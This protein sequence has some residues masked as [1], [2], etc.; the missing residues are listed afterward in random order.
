MFPALFCL[1]ASKYRDKRSINGNV[2]G[3]LPGFYQ[4]GKLLKIIYN[5]YHL[6]FLDIDDAT[7][8]I[9]SRF[10]IFSATPRYN[11]TQSS[12][13]CLEKANTTENNPHLYIENISQL[14]DP[15]INAFKD[16]LNDFRKSAKNTLA[17]DSCKII[18]YDKDKADNGYTLKFFGFTFLSFVLLV[19]LVIVISALACVFTFTTCCFCFHGKNA[20]FPGITATVFFWIAFSLFLIAAFIRISSVSGV[21]E[22]VSPITDLENK[23]NTSLTSLSKFLSRK[24]TKLKVALTNIPK[25]RRLIDLFL[26]VIT[27]VQDHIGD[28]VTNVNKTLAYTKDRNGTTLFDRFDQIEKDID[29]F[30]AK[31]EEIKQRNPSQ[32]ADIKNITKPDFENFTNAINDTLEQ[33]KNLSLHS[34]IDPIIDNLQSYEFIDNITKIINETIDL[35]FG[36]DPVKEYITIENFSDVIQFDKVKES[37]I[38]LR[39]CLIILFVIPLFWVLV[40]L[41]CT[42]RAFYSHGCCSICTASCA[43][44]RLCCCTI[45]FGLFC[46]IFTALGVVFNVGG[47]RIYETVNVISPKLHLLFVNP[48]YIL[49]FNITIHLYDTLVLE[50]PQIQLKIPEIVLLGDIY[51][52]TYKT[53]GEFIHAKE[54]IDDST[55]KE[56]DMTFQNFF[57]ETIPEFIQ[58]KILDQKIDEEVKKQ[59][60]ENIT[61]IDGYPKNITEDI[62]EGRDQIDKAKNESKINESDAKE[63]KEILQHL[64]KIITTELPESYHTT[65]QTIDH[66]VIQPFGTKAGV[67]GVWD[68][69][70]KGPYDTLADWIYNRGIKKGVLKI[71]NVI[72][73]FE[74]IH[75]LNCY[76]IIT[77]P[78]KKVI[79][80]FAKRSIFYFFA[81]IA[82]LVFGISLYVRRRGMEWPEQ[83]AKGDYIC[84]KKKR[85]YKSDSGYG[86]YSY[87]M[88]GYGSRSLSGK[89]GRHYSSSSGYSGSYSYSYSN[90]RNEFYNGKKDDEL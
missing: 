33:F 41:V 22:I 62:K 65:Y 64:E 15:A 59:I 46:L 30:N 47:N 71:V 38:K 3:W 18:N 8:K 77:Y 36:D 78:C 85:G 44:C 58:K 1:S 87:S 45:Y 19:G 5:K 84:G 37:G 6:D 9:I 21:N 68:R 63:L 25:I 61:D 60:P 53:F 69:D 57:N 49:P 50:L 90:K 89:N 17:N 13:S 81:L 75:I 32:Q 40:S 23:I 42:T 16:G 67:K 74:M 10:D 4:S 27:N 51:D 83:V 2:G 29:K 72:L 82:N 73:D 35:F 39:N 70:F 80:F 56:L 52:E 43:C 66:E 48:F 54:I 7:N 79:Y 14:K 11:I 28:I 24:A 26:D 34:F 76:N 55:L 31:L 20:D 12:I 86:S 88:S